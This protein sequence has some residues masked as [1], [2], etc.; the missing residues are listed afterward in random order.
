ML[1]VLLLLA[2]FSLIGEEE[3]EHL[4]LGLMAMMFLHLIFTRSNPVVR[5][6]DWTKNFF[7]LSFGLCC[8]SGVA[9]S[10][11]DLPFFPELNDVKEI[12]TVHFMSAYWCIVLAAIHV[13]EQTKTIVSILPRILCRIGRIVVYAMSIYGVFVL[14]T[15]RFALFLVVGKEFGQADYSVGL[16][17]FF[18]QLLAVFMLIAVA[19]VHAGRLLGRDQHDN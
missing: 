11:Y 5:S 13:G 9:L 10:R 15:T 6:R 4:S 2:S 12:S 17:L 14:C 7:V 8:L 16:G 18:L 19:S 3:H 1:I